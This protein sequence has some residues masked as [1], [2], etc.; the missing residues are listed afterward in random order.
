M[1][2]IYSL[3]ELLFFAALYAFVG[4]ALEVCLIAITQRRFS[5]RGFLNLPM[6]MSFGVT[7]VIL[8]LTLPELKEN[9]ALQLLMCVAVTE[10]VRRFSELFSR[11]V[12]D[13][14]MKQALVGRRRIVSRLAL[15]ALTGSIYY[16]LYLIVHPVIYGVVLLLPDR[17]IRAIAILSAVLVALDFFTVRYALYSASSRRMKEET[18]R[19]ADRMGAAIWKRLERAY[20]GADDPQDLLNGSH[21]FARGLCFDKLVWVFLISSLLGALIEMAYC[22]LT[23]G[24]LMNRSSVL[25]G[26]FSFVWGFGA[27]VLTVT[28]QRFMG[29]EDRYTFLAGFVVGGAYE[30]LCSVFTER[31]FGT[32]FWDYSHMTLSIAGGR[33]NV[34]YCVFWGILSV[35]WVKIL[36]P[37]MARG[38]ERIPP[39]AGK[40]ATWAI[41][42]VM[43]CNGLLTAA[44][45]MRYTERHTQN[46]PKGQIHM[47]ID[48]Q[49]DDAYMEERWPN[50]KIAQE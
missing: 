44:A 41:M 26:P 34:V 35:V 7:A 11:G 12:G 24:G 21:T 46:P 9:T 22:Y 15:L 31:V 43:A 10:T 2:P 39:L 28:L 14:W 45:M 37:T 19:L 30:C 20:P 27:V 47:L 13:E 29:R 4:W 16:L 25:Y 32:V 1:K 38:I 48:A 49:Y 33:T 6:K 3:D 8:L 50:M 18:N 40:I 23:G 42:I 5:N 36:Y 17:L